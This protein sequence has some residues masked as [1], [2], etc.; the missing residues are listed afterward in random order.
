MRSC[1]EPA[2]YT[3]S[4]KSKPSICEEAVALATAPAYKVSVRNHRKPDF[5]D[6]LGTILWIL[7]ARFVGG[8]VICFDKE[9]CPIFPSLSTLFKQHRSVFCFWYFHCQDRCVV[10]RTLNLLLSLSVKQ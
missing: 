5:S 4:F 7:K 10:F 2:F 6:T 1:S 8:V 3:W 9:L